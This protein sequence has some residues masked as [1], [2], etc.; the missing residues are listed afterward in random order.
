MSVSCRKLANVDFSAGCHLGIC[1]FAPNAKCRGAPGDCILGRRRITTLQEPHYERMDRL[2]KEMW[3]T[4]AKTADERRAK[5]EVLL[6]CV[7]RADWRDNDT[8]ADY[9]I[10]MARDLLFEFVGG[11]RANVLAINSPAIRSHA[12]DPAFSDP[13]PPQVRTVASRTRWTATT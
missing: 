13:L 8:D 10:R 9:D 5:V 12:P 6:V 7:M 2:I 11:Q 3:A 1:Q 4:P